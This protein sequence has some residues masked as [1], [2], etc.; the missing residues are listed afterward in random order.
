VSVD[1][2]YSYAQVIAPDGPLGPVLEIKPGRV[3]LDAGRA[4]HVTA[5]ITIAIPGSWSMDDGPVWTP[6]PDTLASLDPR[7]SPPPRVVITAGNTATARTFNLAVVETTVNR[8]EGAVTVSLA[9]DESLL[10]DYAPDA[11]DYTPFTIA[12]D[13]LHAVANYVVGRA[14]PGASVVPLTSGRIDITPYWSVT[15]MLRNPA[16]VGSTLNWSPGGG[17]TLSYVSQGSSGVVRAAMSAAGGAVFMVD[18]TK[19]NVSGTAGLT[20]NA[21]VLAR[22]EVPFRG[23]ETASLVLRFLDAN[24]GIITSRPG[25]A[26]QMQS[27]E[28]RKL[29][30]SAVAPA[31]TA[32][33]APYV[34]IVGS[35]AGRAIILDLGVLYEGDP[36]L[37]VEPFTG[38]DLAAGG[39]TY[40]FEGDPND[41]PSVRVPTLERDPRALVWRAGQSALDFLHPLLQANGWRLVCDEQRYWTMRDDN[42]RAELGHPSL[43]EGV[44][45]I[46]AGD[47]KGRKGDWCDART[48]RY[49]WT[50]RNGI[51]QEREDV[52]APTGY[53]RMSLLEVDAPYPGP[54]RSEY[55]VHRAAAAGREVTLTARADWATY[56]EQRITAAAPDPIEHA[57]TRSVEFD[58]DNDRMTV[59]VQ[60]REDT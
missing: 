14:I 39:Y 47:T 49:R 12:S 4:P 55:A 8:R 29:T 46:E 50:D 40:R 16:V 41:S 15:N 21:S 19:Y 34:N 13:G 58:L 43:V 31:G 25:P 32:K 48:T 5:S 22:C 28:Y 36:R 54:G 33:I 18:T 37:P 6:D 56:P 51:R 17:C 1:V 52:Y 10:E 38:A 60:Q 53:T 30:N 11:D 57:V 2:D 20:Y 9:S 45:V 42:Y 7:Q 59:T 27:G 26:V 44:N 23:G 35:A 3:A 24:N